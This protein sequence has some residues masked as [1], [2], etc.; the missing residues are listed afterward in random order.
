MNKAH[1]TNR[2]KKEVKGSIFDFPDQEDNF[3]TFVKR[4]KILEKHVE[5]ICSE[6]KKVVG[7][8]LRRNQWI[9]KCQAWQSKNIGTLIGL[10]PELVKVYSLPNMKVKL[11]FRTLDDL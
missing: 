2:S 11:Y 5:D 10:D 8:R 7:L 3:A 9:Q 6:I 4:F 1:K